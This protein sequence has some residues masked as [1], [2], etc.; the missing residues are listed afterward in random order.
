MNSQPLRLFIFIDSFGHELIKK[1]GLLL[2]ETIHNKPLR[3]QFGY[4]ATAIPSILTGQKPSTHGQFT[5]FYRS[6]NGFS[7]FKFFDTIWFKAIPK[8]ISNRRRFRVLLSRILKRYFKIN[9]Y[10]DL[11]SVPFDRLKYFDYSE[12]KDLFDSN[13]FESTKNLK[14]LLLENNISHFISDWRKSEDEN[15]TDLK[16]VVTNEAPS[17]IFAYFAG[18]DGVQHMYTKDGKETLDKLEYYRKNIL[19]L[20]NITKEKYSD[21]EFAIFS[22]HGMTS[23]EKEVNIKPLL[24][25]SGLKFGEDYLSFIDSTMLRIWYLNNHSKELLRKRIEAENIPGRFLSI[26]EMKKW[27]VYF[28]DGKY[29][30]DIFLVDPGVQLN[31]SDMGNMALPGMHGYDPSDKD[32]DAVWMSNFYPEKDPVEVKDI[33]DCMLEKINQIKKETHKEEV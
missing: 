21:V 3:M 8:F 15:F 20:L 7:I 30:D 31:P 28:E 6:T 32:S 13:A 23:L 4:S 11:Y 26:E 33:F 22:D 17:F 9:G 24:E 14:D 25:E 19:N 29:G 5:F 1:H 18:L 12:K 2:P 10:F 27:G 16:N